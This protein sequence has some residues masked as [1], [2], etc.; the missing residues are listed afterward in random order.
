ML[1]ISVLVDN[2]ALIGRYFLAEPGFSLWIECGGKKILFDAG[3]S[4]I[5]LR[6]ARLMGIDAA[7]P[8]TVVLSHG[9][10]D[11]TWGLSALISER[12]ARGMK[13]RPALVCHPGAL[14]RKKLRGADAGMIIAPEVLGSFFD[15]RPSREVMEIAENLYWLGEI[16]PLVTPRGTLG[17]AMDEGGEWRP[18]GCFDDSALV[19]DG[20][21]G[22]VIITGCSHSGICNIVEQA[23]RATRREKIADVIGGFHLRSGSEEE[24]RPVLSYFEK[25]APHNVHACHCTCFAARAALA[26]KFA[27]DELGVSSVFEFK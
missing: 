11:H 26:A 12:T 4:G 27:A 15:L 3:Y 19:Y 18:D 22:L 2:N 7:A 23:K 9:H 25:A 5:F 24:M 14:A 13:D 8:D 10:S 1:K 16:E 20:A 21:D 6:N 17:E